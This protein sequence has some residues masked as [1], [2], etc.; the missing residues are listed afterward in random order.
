MS[1]TP[2]KSLRELGLTEYEAKIYLT[3]L[4]Y[5]SLEA[6]EAANESGVPKTKVY[7][8]LEDLE[9]KGLIVNVQ[10]RS[11]MKYMLVDPKIALEEFFEPKIK[12]IE[13]EIETIEEESAEAIK[14]LEEYR[15]ERKLEPRLKIGKRPMYGR[16]IFG[17]ENMFSYW[18]RQAEKA[19]EEI[20]IFSVGEEIPG[21]ASRC[22]M[23]KLEESVPIRFITTKHD[24]ENRRIIE[25]RKKAGWDVRYYPSAQDVAFTVIDRKLSMINL[26][27]PNGVGDDR[28]SF[29]FESEELTRVLYEY[30]ENIWKRH[31]MSV[32]N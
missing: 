19:R 28:V 21:Y 24:D 25:W 17:Y 14:L 32:Y 6:I 20:L 9:K 5:P 13:M 4:R 2:L 22:L 16:P 27:N 3:F 18:T 30:F 15:L 8:C 31:A 7:S 23:K 10:E 1:E 11:P 26:R 29:F 12:K